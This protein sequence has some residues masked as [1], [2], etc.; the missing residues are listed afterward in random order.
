M[1]GMKSPVGSWCTTLAWMLVAHTACAAV[2]HVP[3]EQPSIQA[4]IESVATGDTVLVA[5]G[6][7]FENLDMR[8]D[9]VVLGQQG[10][11]A[12]VVDGQLLGPVVRCSVVHDFIIDGFT[13]RNGA[14]FTYGAGVSMNFSSGTI[15][16]CRVIDN[17]GHYEGGG[18]GVHSGAATIVACEVRDNTADQNGGGITVSASDVEIHDCRVTGNQANATG[19]FDGGG[20]MCSG[21]SQLVVEDT[22]IA[23]NFAHEGGGVAVTTPASSAAIRRCL[24][25]GNEATSTGVAGGAAISTQASL[26][27][28]HNTI[29]ENRTGADGGSLALAVGGTFIIRN[30]IVAGASGHGLICTVPISTDCNDIWNSGGQNF[31]GCPPGPHDFSADPLFC[32][33]ALDDFTLN[34]AS[35]CAPTNSPSGCGLI[36][37]FNVGCG[38]VAVTPASWGVV[39]QVYR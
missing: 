16:N 5:P 8:G 10:A 9:I 13:I 11:D 18:I 24:V 26:L 12:T 19:D 27:A 31:V 34:Q 33:P 7:Y 25:R 2:V 39:K 38:P 29:I 20:I 14:N 22:I 35:P 37:A 3:A 30:N 21:A 23:N 6:V 17:V 15:R 36:G 1:Q 4:G 28:E 32:N